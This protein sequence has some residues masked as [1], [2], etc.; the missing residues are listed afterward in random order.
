MQ[1]SLPQAGKSMT[2]PRL[3][4]GTGRRGRVELRAGKLMPRFEEEMTV[5]GIKM[6]KG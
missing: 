1:N 6:M 2:G 3:T 4:G 5:A